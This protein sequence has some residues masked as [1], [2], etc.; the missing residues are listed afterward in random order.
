M[1]VVCDRLIPD[2]LGEQLPE[3][4]SERAEAEV[5]REAHEELV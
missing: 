5:P 1:C 4:G 2:R 3:V